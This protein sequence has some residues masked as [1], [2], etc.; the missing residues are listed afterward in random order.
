LL[1][2]LAYLARMFAGVSVY[3]RP[4][5]GDLGLAADEVDL[6]GVDHQVFGSF[7][8]VCAIPPGHPLAKLDVITP[9]DLDGVDY[10]A[11]SPEDRARLRL[12][13]VCD[14]A[15]SKPRLVTETPNSATV[16]ALALEGVGVGV[17]NPLSAD[18]FAERGVI[19]RPLQ[20]ARPL[21]E[22]SAVSPR[23]AE[24]AHRPRLRCGPAKGA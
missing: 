16:C 6:T 23:R 11:L 13:K 17:V 18:G 3:R 14:E 24:G 10:I 9:W 12:T 19:F 20:P 2:A 22:L 5:R 4:S 1:A 8:G 7:P 15:G 21:Q